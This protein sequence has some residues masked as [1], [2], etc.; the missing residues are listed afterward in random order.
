MSKAVTGE[1]LRQPW[2][3]PVMIYAAMGLVIS[4]LA[5]LMAI[6]GLQLGAVR[7][8]VARVLRWALW[9]STRLPSRH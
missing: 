3:L 2:L 7:R 8:D 4:M 5:H 1:I 9:P 6:D